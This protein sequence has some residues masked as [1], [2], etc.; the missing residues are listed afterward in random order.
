MMQKRGQG[1]FLHAEDLERRLGTLD[2]VGR[3]ERGWTRLAWTPEDERAGE[4]F[5]AQAAEL[6]LRVERDPAGN[7]WAL[8]PGDGPWWGVGSHLDTVR[9]GGRYDGAL[10]VAAAFA[11]AAHAP[12]AVI[13][14]ADEEG[15]RFNTPTFGSR[16][17]VGR[18]HP[19]RPEIAAAMREAGVDPDRIVEAPHWLD[20]LKGF[21]ELHIDQAPGMATP[22]RTVERL[23]A[24]MRLRIELEGRA[25]HAGTTPPDQREDALAAAA[26]LVLAARALNRPDRRVTATALEIRPNAATTIAARATLL[27]DARGE[28]LDEVHARLGGE[29]Q[30]RSQPAVF[31]LRDDAPVTCWAGHDAGMLADRIPAGMVLVRN[32]TGVSHSPDEHVDLAD[33]ALA[34]GHL[35]ERV[36]G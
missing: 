33:A 30:S 24:R 3:G 15:A 29:V 2:P 9:E 13:S 36:R 11:I 22:Y 27:V 7:R 18:P 10:G 16:A 21:L 23:A 26:E 6:G 19:L 1:P 4:W 28:D 8:P 34:A 5:A 20:R 17:L 35:L 32:P 31:A 25:D 12:V 14:F